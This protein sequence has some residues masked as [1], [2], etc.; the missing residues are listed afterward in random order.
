V[1]IVSS[2]VLLAV[3]L[4]PSRITSTTP[5]TAVSVP[6]VTMNAL[7]PTFCTSSAFTMPTTTPATIA[8]TI[9]RKTP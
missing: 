1:A 9:A 7:T 8:K 6:R 2:A 5:R 3:M 4:C